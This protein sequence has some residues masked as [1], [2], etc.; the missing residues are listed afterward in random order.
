MREKYYG[1]K[2]KIRSEDFLYSYAKASTKIKGILPGKHR[3]FHKQNYSSVF[4]NDY[5]FRDTDNSI[6]EGHFLKLNQ[7]VTSDL[8]CRDDTA[9]LQKGIR[10][11]LKRHRAGDRFWALPIEGLEEICSKIDAMDSTLP[12][13]YDGI[14]CG[15][16]DFRGEKLE[17]V[18][19][20]YTV[21]VRNINPSYLSV[22]FCIFLTEAKQKELQELMGSNYHNNRGYAKALLTSPKNGGAFTTY[23]VCKYVNAAIKSD[24][25]YEW[26]SYIEWEF[27]DSLKTYLPFLLHHRLNI[28][29]PR[30]DVFLTD[31]DYR[32]KVDA[33]WHSV[34]V[35][36][37]NGQFIDG[38][39]KMFFNYELS[40]RYDQGVPTNRLLYIVKD[41]GIEIGQLESVKDDVY[42]H[43][44][45][46]A[47]EYFRFMFLETLSYQSANVIVKYKRE[48]DK[49][50]LKKNKLKQLLKLR[51]RFVRDID[52][53]IRYITDNNWDRSIQILHKKIYS[54]SDER[55]KLFR[56]PFYLSYADWGRGI[57]SDANKLKERIAALQSEFGNKGQILQHL[58]NY[59]NASRSI[60][61]NVIMIIIAAITLF[62]VIFPSRAT[63][64]ADIIRNWFQKLVR[65][66]R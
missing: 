7:I 12:S 61:L 30:I 34:G 24:R 44:R 53:F 21:T 40:G 5:T 19:D 8:I 10:R 22:E 47:R 50:K 26:I 36:N 20:Y 35:K 31:I 37:Y 49:I 13:W 41:D 62:F 16:F 9:S 18:I 63:W 57:V 2:R 28:M 27:Y 51:Y 6:P 64:L 4:Q 42:F 38:R 46:C 15:A 23:T 65:L 60:V 1:I 17:S 45:E 3:E 58:A 48:L 55:M 14:R 54:E 32:E 25:I 11:L 59:R 66:L 39:H 52:N 56:R 33:F 43:I 29:P